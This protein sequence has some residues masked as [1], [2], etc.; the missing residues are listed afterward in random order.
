MSIPCAE[1]PSQFEL[2]LPSLNLE[3]GGAVTSHVVRGWTWGPASD[4]EALRANLR[5]PEPVLPVRRAA[6]PALPAPG[7]LEASLPTVVLVHALTG[8]ADVTTWWEPLVGPGKVLDPS[9]H[10]LVAFNL[11]GS[12]YGSSGPCDADFPRDAVVTTKDQARSILLALDALGIDRVALCAGGSIGALVTLQLA[13][14]G[15]SRFERIA[16]IAGA[17]STSAWVIGWNHVARGILRLDPGFPEAVQEGLAIARQLAILTYR[18]E[19]GLDRR[20]HRTRA[21][22]GEHSVE[23][24]LDHQ[25]EKLVRRFDGRAY[26]TLLG[27]MDAHEVGDGIDGVRASV[28]SVAIDSD[29]LFLPAQ[30][31]RISDALRAR[32]RIAEDAVLHSPHGHDAFLIEW[33]QVE[34]VL[35]RALA[36]EVRS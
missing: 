11:L 19:D 9:R 15:G 1:K 2:S 32:G 22:G 29:Q 18:A 27:A 36:L 25:G 4:V 13:A 30:A 6:C 14:L 21:H 33:S 5:D 7:R 35:R 24:Y 23:T 12:C 10:R 26:L 34:T 31:R 16:P 28:L 17:L 20:Q 3:R 8:G